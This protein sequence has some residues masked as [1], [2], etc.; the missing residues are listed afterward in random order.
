[1]AGRQRDGSHIKPEVKQGMLRVADMRR[2]VEA[3]CKRHEIE[4]L[5]CRRPMDAWA[6]REHAT[7]GIAPIKSRVSYATAL[8]EIGHLRGRYQGSR[9]SMVRE[10][11]AWQWAKANALI[12]TPRMER[13]RRKSLAL[14]RRN[15]WFRPERSASPAT[16]SSVEAT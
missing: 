7:V 8:H 11:W 10:R 4:F 6:D 16:A 3:L 13:D 14:A 5:W 1:M 2:H 15:R 9:D 12:W